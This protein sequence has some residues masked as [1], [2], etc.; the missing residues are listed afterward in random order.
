MTRRLTPASSKCVA[1]ECRNVCTVAAFD[2]PLSR[3]AALKARCTPLTDMGLLALAGP[4]PVRVGLGK[5]HTG[6][7]CV[8]QKWRNWGKIL[9]GS[10]TLLNSFGATPLK[11][12]V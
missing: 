3:R 11:L 9:A 2:T 6:W 4:S 12:F 1:Y 10:G 8:H 7:R 5:S